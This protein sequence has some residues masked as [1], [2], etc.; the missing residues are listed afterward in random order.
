MERVSLSKGT[1]EAS[2]TL[3]KV[4][5]TAPVLAFDNYTKPFQLETDM[6]K[7]GLGAVLSQK[8]TDRRYHPV[9]TGSRALRPHEKNYHLTKLDF[10]ALKWV[11]MEHF[12][13]YLAY[14]PFLVKTDNSPLTYIMMMPNLN[15]TGHQ[16]VGALVRFNFQLE[17]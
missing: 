5:M 4:C 1:V 11:V 12:K 7:D 2:K 10:L 9:A 8:Q 6:S 14:Q 13:E 16:W 3:K 17:Y 15:A